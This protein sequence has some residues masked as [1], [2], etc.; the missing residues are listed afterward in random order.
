[1]ANSTDT[2]TRAGLGDISNAKNCIILVCILLY[3][4]SIRAKF[5]PGPTPW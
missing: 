1:M 2:L 4:K 3:D 5:N